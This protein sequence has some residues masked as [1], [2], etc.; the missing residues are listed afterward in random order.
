[1]LYANC[2]QGQ[3]GGVGW[4][5]SVDFNANE[6]N[7][8][9]SD[10]LYDVITTQKQLYFAVGFAKESE[11]DPSNRPDVPAF[12]LIG[13]DGK[14]L[15]TGVVE[16]G[17]PI[18]PGRLFNAL[19]STAHFYAVG[20]QGRSNERKG[21][22]VRIDKGTFQATSFAITPTGFALAR[23]SDIEEVVDASGSKFLM[24]S[25]QAQEMDNSSPSRQWIATYTL[26][27]VKKHE[28]VFPVA[29]SGLS[30]RMNGIKFQ[31]EGNL[32]KAYYAAAV[33]KKLDGGFGMH[34][35][36]DADIEVGSIVYD[37]VAG[38]FTRTSKLHN[39][40]E[41][42][43]RDLQPMTGV[44][45]GTIFSVAQPSITDLYPYGPK[46]EGSPFA[47][48]IPNCNESEPLFDFF[49]EDWSDGSEDEPHGI[50]VTSDKVVVA[51]TLNRL[52]M[53]AGTNDVL[54]NDNKEPGL[55][56]YG[57][58]ANNTAD[59]GFTML[60][61]KFNTTLKGSQFEGV[62]SEVFTQCNEY[63][64]MGYAAFSAVK[65]SGVGQ[66]NAQGDNLDFGTRTLNKFFDNCPNDN[67][68]HIF[69]E[70]AFDYFDKPDN[71]NAPDIDCVSDVVSVSLVESELLAPCEDGFTGGGN[72]GSSGGGRLDTFLNSGRTLMDRNI[73]LRGLLHGDSILT[74]A[75]VEDILTVLRTRNQPNDRL[76]LVG[77]LLDLRRNAEAQ[78]EINLL[79]STDAQ[80]TAEKAYLQAIL[81]GGGMANPLSDQA[82]QSALVA[83]DG[84]SPRASVLAQNLRQYR[85]GIEYPLIMIHDPVGN[86]EAIQ[87]KRTNRNTVQVMPNPT[88][89]DIMVDLS[90]F[91]AHQAILIGVFDLRGQ[92]V[93]QVRSTGSA[94]ARLSLSNLAAGV[95]LLR[96]GGEGIAPTTFRI[97]KQ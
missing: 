81:D 35:R 25:G 95:Y 4:T 62:N 10:W 93:A 3:N 87:N 58:V 53:F 61:N 6:P 97:V 27:G 73:A 47:R 9:N 96:V 1:M 19:E 89:S 66:L 34:R 55:P 38:T 39:S 14:L 48:T 29:A 83:I 60:I 42:K 79:N 26:D 46:Y 94:V 33:Q 28:T 5:T 16:Q 57:L 22:L 37:P 52:I 88:D 72:D 32:L 24:L 44:G 8:A 90:S 21:L 51:A 84:A 11:T 17:S 68:K 20:Y 36:H 50:V 49:I 63:S 2:L 18:K 7:S 41:Q 74:E 59:G 15:N 77:T 64:G 76:L 69:S 80:V 45:A 13:Q 67:R 65:V 85:T 40:V 54:G 71:I 56:S 75:A 70:F 30:E 43:D 78:A 86:R 82:F 12:C 31:L 91:D 92:L 23:L